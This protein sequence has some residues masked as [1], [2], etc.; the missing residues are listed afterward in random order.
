[1]GALVTR[2]LVA[3]GAC[4]VLALLAIALA[5][6]VRSWRSGL[7]DGDAVYAASPERASWI[8]RTRLGGLAGNLLGVDDDVD[9]RRALRLYRATAGTRLRLD[10]ATRVQTARAAAQDALL[11]AARSS[12]PARAS[13]ART[14]LGILTFGQSASGGAEDQVEGAVADFTDAVRADGTNDD[15][16]FD[17]ELLLRSSAATGTRPGQGVGGGFGRGGRRGAG[18]G[19]PGK[20]Y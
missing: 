2:L 12:D 16:K 13:Q 11:A 7:R 20:G 17:L 18:G 3:A 4:V 19:T 15:A 9:A 10:N 1:M 8:P 14:L 6:D 5:A